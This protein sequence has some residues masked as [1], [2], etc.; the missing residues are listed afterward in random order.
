MPPDQL[1]VH[2]RNT[3]SDISRDIRPIN[4]HS[5][6]ESRHRSFFLSL[7]LLLVGL[8]LTLAVHAGEEK[9]PTDE[10]VIRPVK[11]M[12]LPEY[13]G[14]T[15]TYPGTVRATNR[16]ELSFNVLGTIIELPV[17]E[18]Q[19]VKKGQL[20][21][22]L[23]PKDYQALVTGAKAEYEKALADYRR[24][25]EL[26]KNGYVS[27]SDYDK[28][29]SDKEVAASRLA[30][31]RKSLEDTYLRAPFD[32]VIAR[33][34]VENFT[35]VRAKQPVLSLQDTHA[36][37]VVAD[38]PEDV[39][40]LNRSSLPTSITARFSV[41]PG[42]EFPVTISEIATHADPVTRTYQ[43][44]FALPAHEGVNL[45]PGMTAEVSVTRG[46]KTTEGSPVFTITATAL[47]EADGK[48]WVWVIDPKTNRVSRREVQA[49][50]IGDRAVVSQGL[51][52]LERIATAGVHHLKE[53]QVV[54]PVTEIR[55]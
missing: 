7:V 26:V 49:E 15:R 5:A 44:V 23:D 3:A 12:V 47:L 40:A 9:I 46:S 52:P 48:T 39:I 36:L 37:E 51:R 35:D 2:A 18:G 14:K 50:V 24:A 31:A 30:R 38:L 10:S 25:K 8:L 4:G 13:Q 45:L 29:V 54:K 21:A 27:R 55:Y 16:V 11:S 20:L 53:G 17:K 22:R 6:M 1:A 34:Y 43:V 28:T 41:L 32:G 42:R 33:R 19:R